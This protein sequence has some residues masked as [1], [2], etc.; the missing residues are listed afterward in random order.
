MRTKTSIKKDSTGYDNRF[1]NF[2]EDCCDKE[3]NTSHD[4]S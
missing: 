1:D 2:S 3:Q 4:M